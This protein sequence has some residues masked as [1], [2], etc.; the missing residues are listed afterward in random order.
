MRAKGGE[1]AVAL[2]WRSVPATEAAFTKAH[3]RRCTG[4]PWARP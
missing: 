2:G 1:L 4:L 3:L